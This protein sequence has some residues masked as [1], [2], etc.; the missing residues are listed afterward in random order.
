MN[1]RIRGENPTG[2]ERKF[3]GFLSVTPR[4][5]DEPQSFLGKERNSNRITNRRRICALF[6]R[7]EIV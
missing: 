6:Y 5:G 2:W 7:F 1:S 4:G 3:W